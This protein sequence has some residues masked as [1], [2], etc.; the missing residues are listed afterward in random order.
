[1]DQIWYIIILLVGSLICVHSSSSIG[2]PT[3]PTVE[4][5]FGLAA[6]E[7]A[8]ESTMFVRKVLLLLRMEEKGM[9]QKIRRIDRS[10]STDSGK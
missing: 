8:S 6:D 3:V 4:F 2:A 9:S 1:M 10:E 5:F 7:N